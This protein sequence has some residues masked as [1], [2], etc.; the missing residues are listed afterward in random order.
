MIFSAIIAYD[1]QDY[2]GSFA[3]SDTPRLKKTVRSGNKDNE[4]RLEIKPFFKSF[5]SEYRKKC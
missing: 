2:R 3:L 4:A 5:I 1:M